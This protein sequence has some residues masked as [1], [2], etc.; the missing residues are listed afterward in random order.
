MAADSVGWSVARRAAL[1]G[2]SMVENSA[3]RWAVCSVASMVDTTAG[4]MDE[5]LVVH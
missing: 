2:T 3:A 1:R 5:H 4:T